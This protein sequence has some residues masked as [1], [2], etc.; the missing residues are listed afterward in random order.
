MNRLIA[1]IERQRG[2]VRLLCA[3]PVPLENSLDFARPAGLNY[4]RI[5]VFAGDV[6]S[7]TLVGDQTGR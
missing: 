6:F 5:N 1:R 4:L 7:L 2:L 3:V